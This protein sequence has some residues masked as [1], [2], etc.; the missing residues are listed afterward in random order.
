MSGFD[1][2]YNNLHR[3]VPKGSKSK[4]K[5]LESKS[6][7]EGQDSKKSESSKNPFLA[8]FSKLF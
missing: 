1:L 3:N 6:T 4:E 7:Q 8:L 5:V 2:L